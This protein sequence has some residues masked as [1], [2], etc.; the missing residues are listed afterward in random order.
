MTLRTR[1]TD[2]L[3]RSP[4]AP[5]LLVVTDSNVGS[6]LAAGA[7]AAVAVVALRRDRRASL[8]AQLLRTRFE[9]GSLVVLLDDPQRREAVA[10]IATTVVCGST[11]LSAALGAAV[12]QTLSE[13]TS[14]HS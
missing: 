3:A 2:T 9:T 12:E 6:T 14:S 8:V 5:S 4:S 7:G 1:L 11:C 10:D 13:P